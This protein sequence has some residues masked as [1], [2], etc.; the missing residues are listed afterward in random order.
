MP[1]A[2][3]AGS[4]IVLAAALAGLGG[5]LRAPDLGAGMGVTLLLMALVT[6]GVQIHERGMSHWSVS[7]STVVLAA[8]IP[9]AGPVGTTV[10]AGLPY[11]TDFRSRNWRTRF[12]NCGMTA[13]MGAAG[14]LVYLATGGVL[15]DDIP[16]GPGA[17]LLR[18]GAPL[19]LAYVAMIGVNVLCIG[20]VS[21][22]SRGTRVL[23]VAESVLRSLGW[24]Y[25][26]H[27]ATGFL[28]VVLWGPVG[29]G[30]GSA[31]FVLGPLLIAHWAIGR[32]ALARREHQETVTTFVAALEEADPSSVG[33]SARVADL[34]EALA[35]QLGVG[36]PEAEDLRYAALLHDIGI[37]VVRADLPTDPQ[38]EIAYLSALSAHPLAGVNVLEGLDF[39]E[40]SLPG[41]AHHH[42]RWD[43]RG[44]PAGLRAEE[45]PLAARI[46]AVA[47]A[48]DALTG[49][50]EDGGC[51]AP[52]ALQ[53]LRRRVG[54][55]LDPQVVEALDGVLARPGS[56]WL[57]GRRPT[58]GSTDKLLPDHDHPSIS[59][60]FADWQPESSDLLFPGS[61]E[62]L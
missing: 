5:L 24:G 38:D 40:D 44:Y 18:V 27:A 13:T 52:E 57:G 20:L 60:A 45:I 33:H 32:D 36:A 7:V 17:L 8:A 35:E 56:P 42:E 15:V 47:D 16:A 26:S 54:S 28:F 14:S 21:A 50:P 31:L 10:A 43:G 30:P 22:V 53:E 51:A 62:A 6:L 48:F 59:D 1:V 23:P 19:L 12:F 41:I 55:H 9:I 46:I 4:L 49:A 25:L 39:L 2:L 58:A 61:G 11:L 29:L 3:L 34:A 37:M